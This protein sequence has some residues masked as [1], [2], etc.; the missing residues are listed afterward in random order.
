[1]PLGVVAVPHGAAETVAVVETMRNK[2]GTLVLRGPMVPTRPFPP[3]EPG[4]EDR[5]APDGFVD[6]GY[7]CKISREAGTFSLSAPPAGITATGFYR[8]RQ[9]EVDAVVATADPSA[10]IVALPDAQLGQRLAGRARDSEAITAEL[11]AYGVNAL[12]AGAFRPRGI[13]A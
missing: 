11:E 4:V 5:F 2:T 8:F 9:S 13:A 3:G 12:I 6:T 10:V 7:V 1:M